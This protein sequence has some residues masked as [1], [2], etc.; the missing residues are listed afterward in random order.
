MLL[1]VGLE[2]KI[3][4]Q[5]C[6]CLLLNDSKVL[7]RNQGGNLLAYWKVPPS[8]SLLPSAQVG[9]LLPSL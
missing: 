7:I 5:P 9:D 3:L 2:I 6:F 8:F 1:S 4:P